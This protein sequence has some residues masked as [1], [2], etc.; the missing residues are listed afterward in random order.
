[1]DHLSS[2]SFL[3]FDSNKHPVGR[4]D[5]YRNHVN[6]TFWPAAQRW[7]QSAFPTAETFTRDNNATGSPLDPHCKVRRHIP[8]ACGVL[9]R[10]A[11]LGARLHFRGCA[12]RPGKR[13]RLSVGIKIK[14]HHS[15]K[16]RQQT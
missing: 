12:V 15:E 13:E 3:P 7:R 16:Q 10:S 14:T 5:S 4:H 6:E 11:S 9:G 1:M 2:S 8:V